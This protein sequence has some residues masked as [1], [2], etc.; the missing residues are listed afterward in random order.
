M[1][2]AIMN[3]K[4]YLLGGFDKDRKPSPQVFVA[5]LDTLLTHQLNW[6]SAPN[7]PWYCS[8]PVV[9]YNMLLLTAGGRQQSRTSEVHIFN[10]STGQWKHLTN[11]PAAR[12]GPAVVGVADNILVIGGLTNENKYSNTIWIGVFV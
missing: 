10:P 12:S 5:S 4:L 9:L 2:A 11:I 6:Q 8:A 1:N 7:T 3:D